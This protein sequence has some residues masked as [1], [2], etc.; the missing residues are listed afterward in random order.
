MT[1]EEAENFI[2]AQSQALFGA[3][4]EWCQLAIADKMT[5]EVIGDIGLCLESPASTLEI[6]F[7]LA[8]EAQGRGLAAEACRAAIELALGVGVEIVEAVI[9][10]RNSSAIALVRRLGMS[11]DR[12]ETADFKD[13]PCSE[14]HFVLPRPT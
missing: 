4:G 13:E 8:P 10:S 12:T 7:T 9:D 2:R 11:L 1:V 6:G 14:H 3:P 5:D